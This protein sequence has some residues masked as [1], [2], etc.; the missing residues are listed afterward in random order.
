[1]SNSPNN[2][3]TAHLHLL[4]ALTEMNTHFDENYIYILTA[5]L[6]KYRKH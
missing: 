4:A 5:N 2:I 6:V 3:H 1:M